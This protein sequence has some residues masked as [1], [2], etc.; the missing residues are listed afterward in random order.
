MADWDTNSPGDSDVI[1]Q[2][3]ANERQQRS[4]VETIFGV[5]HHSENDASQGY[6]DRVTLPAVSRPASVSNG[7]RIWVEIFEGVP[8]LYWRDDENDPVR[9]T[10]KGQLAV[11]LQETDVIVGSLRTRT[12]FRGNV[13]DLEVVDNAVEIDWE[14]ATVFRLDLSALSAQTITVTL[15]NMPDTTSGEEQTIYI[16]LIDGGNNTI[17]FE[18]SYTLLRA[19]NEIVAF[20]EDGRD[21]VIATTHDGANILLGVVT[22]FGPGV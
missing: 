14:A 3:P 16:D 11:N 4:T 13:I 2:Y 18:S 1:S 9:L 21:M 5:D 22:D 20:T 6:H 12:F 10:Y 19:Y 8:E 17:N 7:G 15:T